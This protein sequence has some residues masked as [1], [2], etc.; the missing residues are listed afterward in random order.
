M[1]EGQEPKYF[2]IGGPQHATTLA[3]LLRSRAKILL[4][5]VD[6][7]KIWDDPEVLLG[8]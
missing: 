5:W 8:A 6:D 3:P 4:D 1:A 2:T 7:D